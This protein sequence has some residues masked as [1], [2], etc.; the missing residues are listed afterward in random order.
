MRSKDIVVLVNRLCVLTSLKENLFF[1]DF[2]LL[3]VKHGGKT[4]AG[5][6]VSI[7]LITIAQ[8]WV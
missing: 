8:F 4:C 6:C 2:F 1:V 3:K 5:Q 7:P